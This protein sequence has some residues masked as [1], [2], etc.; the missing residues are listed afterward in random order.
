MQY[1]NPFSG[2]VKDSVICFLFLLLHKVQKSAQI[3]DVIRSVDIYG[4]SLVEHNL[5]ECRKRFKKEYARKAH[6]MKFVTKK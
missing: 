4:R 3:I 2:E 6:Y 1:K 5:K